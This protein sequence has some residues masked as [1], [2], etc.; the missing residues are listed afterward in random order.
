MLPSYQQRL[1][2]RIAE[3]ELPFAWD[4]PVVLI[5]AEYGLNE[6]NGFGRPE[7]LDFLSMYGAAG[8]PAL[9]K[10]RLARAEHD[11]AHVAERVRAA[12]EQ[13]KNENRRRASTIEEHD[14]T[15]RR[16]GEVFG[17]R[18]R[19]AVQVYIEKFGEEA[20][21]N[22]R[23]IANMITAESLDRNGGHTQSLT[24]LMHKDAKTH[25]DALIETIVTAGSSSS[26]S[27]EQAKGESTLRALL[28]P[29]SVSV[30]VPET[31]AAGGWG[32]ALLGA[33]LGAVGGP[34]LMATGAMIGKKYGGSSAAKKAL[35]QDVA[36]AQEN[37]RAAGAWVAHLMGEQLGAA[38]GSILANISCP[39]ANLPKPDQPAEIQMSEALQMVTNARKTARTL[40]T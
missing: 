36:E 13:L 37:A 7:L 38:V 5:S 9:R 33:A 15:L 6:P 19:A 8:S 21:L 31:P 1:R 4:P 20:R 16:Q 18:V 24:R 17:R 26:W 2:D 25:Q 35:A 10:L 27:W 29:I 39:T 28:A 11:L 30:T 12:L 34:A 40:A 3:M 14:A 22:G 23:V 32:T